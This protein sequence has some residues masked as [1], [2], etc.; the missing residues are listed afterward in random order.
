MLNLPATNRMGARTGKVTATH[1]SSKLGETALS[2][3]LSQVNSQI[4]KY[5]VVI[6]QLDL[7]SQVNSNKSSSSSKLGQK[8]VEKTWSPGAIPCNQRRLL[9]CN[10]CKK[11]KAR[12]LLSTGGYH[13]TSNS[14]TQRVCTTRTGVWTSHPKTVKL[15]N[16]NTHRQSSTWTKTP[17]VS[18]WCKSIWTRRT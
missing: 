15:I 6:S 13:L 14:W 3:K 18:T 10:C 9:T 11:V 7:T 12:S 5:Q 2:S 4:I 1:S 16:S 8:V 17:Q